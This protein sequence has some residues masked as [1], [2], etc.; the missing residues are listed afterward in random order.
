[1]VYECERCSKP[2]P[3]GVRACPSCGDQ[4]EE[5]VPA[6]A[7]VPSRGFKART[8][9]NLAPY[10]PRTLQVEIPAPVAP[11]PAPAPAERVFIETADVLVTSTRVQIGGKTYALANLTSVTMIAISPGRCGLLMVAGLGVFVMAI[12]VSSHLDTAMLFGFIVLAVA[13]ILMAV[14]KTKYTVQIKSASAET[15]ALW[16]YNRAYIGKIVEAIKEAIIARG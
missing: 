12:G 16:A 8:E 7:E 6:D 11:L 15:N 13:V 14:A 9:I 2:L 3:A 10:E 5:V 4:F 1:M